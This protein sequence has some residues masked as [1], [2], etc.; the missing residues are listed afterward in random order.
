MFPRIN[1]NNDVLGTEKEYPLNYVFNMDSKDTLQIVESTH[2]SKLGFFVQ[3]AEVHID[4]CNHTV[5]VGGVPKAYSAIT[6][7]ELF[8]SICDACVEYPN[9]ETFFSINKPEDSPYHTALMVFKL[10]LPLD[11][12]DSMANVVKAAI[13]QFPVPLM[14]TK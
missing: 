11:N 13:N 8:S 7:L 6:V 9:I 3:N 2:L 12:F 5:A 10:N 14:K 1:L 4:H